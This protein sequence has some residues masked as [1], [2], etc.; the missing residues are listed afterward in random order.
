MERQIHGLRV[1]LPKKSGFA[2]KVELNTRI[3]ELEGRLARA[4]AGL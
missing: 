3:K 1:A 4:A 2:E